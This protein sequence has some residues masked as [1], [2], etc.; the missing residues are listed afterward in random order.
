MTS[1]IFN[2]K[3]KQSHMN[4]YSLFPIRGYIFFGP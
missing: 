2:Y 3:S 4:A 1:K